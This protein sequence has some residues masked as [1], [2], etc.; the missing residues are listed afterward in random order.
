MKKLLY[1]L[2]LLPLAFLGSCNDDDDTPNVNI[3]ITLGNAVRD[4]NVVYIVKDTPFEIKSIV[5]QGIG[6]KALI[7]N[8]SYYWDYLRVGWN[9]IAPFNRTFDTSYAT[10][11]THILSITCEVAQEG[12]SLGVAAASF[13]VKV[14]DSVE[15]LPEGTEPGDVVITFNGNPE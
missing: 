2:L 4:N 1:I 12:K 13:N 11:G 14:V 10:V 6:S 9:P 8:V 15:E 7:T 3:E 5:A